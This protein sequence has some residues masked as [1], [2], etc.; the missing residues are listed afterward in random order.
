MRFLCGVCEVLC[1]VRRLCGVCEVLC[2]VLCG[3]YVV[4]VRCL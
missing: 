3:V 2:G 1:N 4:F